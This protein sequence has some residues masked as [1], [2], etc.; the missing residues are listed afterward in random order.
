MTRDR[1]GLIVFAALMLAGFLVLLLVTTS[2]SLTAQSWQPYRGGFVSFPSGSV[3]PAQP[4]GTSTPTSAALP[5]PSPAI[6]PRSAP[7]TPKPTQR[8]SGRILP[9]SVAFRGSATW[10]DSWGHGFYA[11]AGPKLRA[12][13]PDYLGK[14]VT[15]C[16]GSRCARVRLTTSCACQPDSRIIDLSLDAFSRLADPSLGVL[17]VTVSW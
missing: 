15:A 7:P 13:Y 12:L 5:T 1:N 9:P 8:P 11:A 14:W 16:A 17:E 6:T 4:G 3:V 2:R 10:W